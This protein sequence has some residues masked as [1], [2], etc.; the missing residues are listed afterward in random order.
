MAG[1]RDQLVKS[2]LVDAKKARQVERDKGKARRSGVKEQTPIQQN[3]ALSKAERDRVLNQQQQEALAQRALD[4]Q[5][6]QMIEGRQLA[7]LPGELPF[8][9][10]HQGI[11]KRRMLA[12]S[13]RD[14]LIQGQI[15][16]VFMDERYAFVPRETA[17]K[18]RDRRPEALLLL[19]EPRHPAVDSDPEARHP[20]PDDLIW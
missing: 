2:G 14:Q 18:I 20:V 19:N 5:V 1:L 6:R 17:I 16:I 8:H 15:G 11:L 3:P 4:A 9:F 7:E 10:N 12:P 13:F